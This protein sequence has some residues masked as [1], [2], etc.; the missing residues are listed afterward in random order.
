ML[1]A[2]ILCALA[3]V[4]TIAALFW[5]AETGET[6]L[7]EARDALATATRHA[8]ATET[9][10]RSTQRQ[11]DALSAQLEAER[12]RA[13]LLTRL[14]AKERRRER[15]AFL[16]VIERQSREA[17]G[18]R[19]ILVRTIVAPHEQAPAVATDWDRYSA[20]ITGDRDEL[21][22]DVQGAGFPIATA[23]AVA[24]GHDRIE[25]IKAR[26]SQEYAEGPELAED[27]DPTS[28]ATQVDREG[29]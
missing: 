6:R 21:D 5:L 16:G 14:A 8:E 29:A 18:E 23:D 28:L 11:N 25:E 7:R 12:Q 13:Y 1:V 2:L 22:G 26:Y 3:L 20:A 9:A 19:Q 4:A 15:G 10:W 17:A 24:F 27:P